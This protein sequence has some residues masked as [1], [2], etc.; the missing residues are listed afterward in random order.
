MMKL[1]LD[2]QPESLSGAGSTSFNGD[3]SIFDGI[4][5][6]DAMGG[7]IRLDEQGQVF[8][9]RQLELIKSGSWD[10]EYKELKADMFIPVDTEG[11]LGVESITYRKFSRIGYAKVISDYA[12]DIPRVDVLGEEVTVQIKTIASAYGYNIFEIARAQRG[13]FNLQQRRAETSTLANLERLDK[14]AWHGS[15]DDGLQG[16]FDYPGILEYV[17]PVGASTFT[18]WDTKTSAEIL[19]D[20]NGMVRLPKT[21]TKGRKVVTQLIM[22]IEQYDII[23]VKQNS[24]ASDITVLQFFLNTH[25][26]LSVD[27]VD[28]LAGAGVDGSDMMMAYIRDPR[29]VAQYRPVP[30][31]TMPTEYKNMEYVVTQISRTGGVVVYY[32]QSVVKAS[33]I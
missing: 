21:T 13:K 29:Q 23:S 1:N 28:D 2:A 22:P 32:P 25:P 9:Q 7:N 33:G 10:V 16:F 19:D 12:T 31:M 5:K 4:L 8:F 15:P 17:I 6:A 14:A 24:D 11:D 27:W 3:L 30:M 26:G 18:E 20:M